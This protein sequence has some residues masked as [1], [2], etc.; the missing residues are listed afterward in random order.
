MSCGVCH[1]SAAKGLG[2]RKV[3]SS[4]AEDVTGRLNLLEHT[5]AHAKLHL[6]AHAHSLARN[7]GPHAHSLAREK[8]GSI[9]IKMEVL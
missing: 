5:V 9:I 1:H 2:K 4:M 3:F 8:Y 6:D 7:L